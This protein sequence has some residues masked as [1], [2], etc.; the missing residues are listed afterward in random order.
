MCLQSFLHVVQG[1]GI[2][3]V[4]A[5]IIE[6]VVCLGSALASIIVIILIATMGCFRVN[7][8]CRLRHA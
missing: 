4:L 8:A 3:L 2:Y 6:Q 1:T 5:D 7:E